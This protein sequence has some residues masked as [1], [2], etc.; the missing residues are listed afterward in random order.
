MDRSGDY[1]AA[2]SPTAASPSS[3]AS[4][5]GYSHS[6]SHSHALSAILGGSGSGAGSGSNLQATVST[7]PL[8]GNSRLSAS[9]PPPLSP[10]SMNQF[11]RT[12]GSLVIHLPTSIDG[13]KDKDSDPLDVSE[14][15]G[16]GH[17]ATVS[18][19]RRRRLVRKLTW[20]T[21]AAVLYLMLFALAFA[22]PAHL[23]PLAPAV[24]GSLLSVVSALYVCVSHACRQ[25]SRATARESAMHALQSSSRRSVDMSDCRYPNQLLVH[26]AVCELGLGIVSL[27]H[28][29]RYCEVDGSSI[30]CRPVSFSSCSVSVAFEMFLLLASVGWFGAAIVHLFVSV[31]NPFANY[32]SQLRVYHLAVWSC[33]ALLAVI[34]PTVLYSNQSQSAYSMTKTELC[35]AV[36]L[37]LPML[38]HISTNTSRVNVVNDWQR[39]NMAYWGALFLVVVLLVVAAQ[40]ILVVGWWRSNSGTVIALKARRRM[41]KR[42]TVYVHTLNATWL[43]V[44]VA[45]FAY[46]SN[47]DSLDHIPAQDVYGSGRYIG[48]D[49]I[50]AA[51][52]YSL[53]AKGF[54]TFVVWIAVNKRDK[55]TSILQRVHKRVSRWIT[56]ILCGRD[57]ESS[58]VFSSIDHEV[59]NT[60]I[61]DPDNSSRVATVCSGVCTEQVR[62]SHTAPAPPSG[63]VIPEAQEDIVSISSSSSSASESFSSPLPSP[64]SSWVSQNN[65]TLQREI[66][67]YTVCGIT[68][69]ILR[70]AQR[71]RDLEASSSVHQLLVGAGRDSTFSN[72]PTLEFVQALHVQQSPRAYCLRDHE[73]VMSR[74]RAASDQGQPRSFREAAYRQQR[75]SMYPVSQVPFELFESEIELQSHGATPLVNV[76]V[77]TDEQPPPSTPSDPLATGLSSRRSVLFSSRRQSLTN[78]EL[79]S[80]SS[81]SISLLDTEP[82][83][84]LFM[85]FAPRAFREVREAFGLSDATYLASFRST[86]KERVSAGS[87]G[88]FMFFTGD[89]SLIVK[90]MRAKECRALVRMAPAY[91]AYIKA[92]PASRLIRVFGCHRLRL[93]G[94]SFYFVVMANVL[95]SSRHCPTV[96]EKYDVKGSWID[97]RSRR[98][99]SGDRVE[100]ADCHTLFT[101]GEPVGRQPM[102]RSDAFLLRQRHRHVPDTVLKD[103]DFERDLHLSES[104]RQALVEQLAADSAFLKSMGIMDYSL[105]IG[106]HTCHF[107]DDISRA[108]SE[109]GEKENTREG[110]NLAPLVGEPGPDGKTEVYFV[111]VIDIL[112]EWDWE[113]KLERAGK[114]L[115]GKSARGISAVAPRWYCRRFQ[116]RVA[117]L[118]LGGPPP[119]ELPEE[120]DDDDGDT[121]VLCTDDGGVGSDD[122][123]SEV[124]E[125]V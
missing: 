61:Q 110:W 103:L 71:A 84:K 27:V 101:V 50:S 25:T 38:P 70:A 18:S 41:M 74:V 65:E 117:Q 10:A 16:E 118:L 20:W 93:Y 116:A 67:Y 17:W 87:S 43:A 95:H 119:E 122:E 19:R 55:N 33:S 86:A 31:S 90:S 44:L 125:I 123:L 45:F 91:A 98:P 111:G 36:A 64:G 8:L 105:L 12:S 92:N 5:D 102:S 35:R 26:V 40:G 115:I 109:V 57:R 80:G 54:F 2:A 97:R 30:M 49:G 89:N 124:G 48:I 28:V 13:D 81:L 1:R 107:E 6:R 62:T 68:K 51:F 46:R 100:C 60:D 78:R 47:S 94:R 63:G 96:N 3:P 77:A 42:M 113:K 99:Q 56:H 7:A 37:V 121:E 39:L 66:I 112:Q 53:A 59:C 79:R 104:T 85:D 23:Q 82:K 83:P 11:R 21:A 114:V 15:H 108:S 58:S 106:V 73:R 9:V 29:F 4:L 24:I 22:L 88:A 120:Q 72:N 14:A 69:S 34:V 76:T 52:H 75:Y 32:R